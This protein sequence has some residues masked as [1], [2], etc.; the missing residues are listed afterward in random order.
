MS[1]RK[2]AQAAILAA[3]FITGCGQASTGAPSAATS[4]ARQQP[5]RTLVIADRHEPIDLAPKILALGGANRTKRLFNASLALIDSKGQ[6]RP[7]LAEALPELNTESWRVQPDGSMDTTYRLRAG[8]K[9]QDGEPFGADDFVFAWQVYDSKVGP[10]LSTPQDQIDSVDAPD[11]RTIVIHW[12]SPYP[13]AAALTDTLLDPLPSHLLSQPFAAYKQDPAARDTF[14]NLSFWT[15]DYIGAGPYKLTNWDHGIS[16]EGQAFDGHALGRPKIDR[17][18]ERIIDNE[19]TV[20]TNVLADEVGYAAR[21]TLRF[22]H[23]K[24]LQ[25][26]WEPAGKGRVMIDPQAALFVQTQFRPEYQRSPQLLDVRVRRALAY[27][28]DKQGILE[29]LYDGES[30]IADTYIS[31]QIPYY[32][33]IDRALTKSP[34]DPRQLGQQMSAAGYVQDSGGFFGRAAGDRFRPDFDVANSVDYER[35]Q[36]IIADSW[37]RA[38]IDVQTTVTPNEQQ[39]VNEVRH[40]VP[41]MTIPG[42]GVGAE[43]DTMTSFLTVQ[44]GS[45]ANRWSGNNRGGWSNAEYDADFDAFN[46]VLDASARHQSVAHAMAVLST[47]LPGFPLYYNIYVE[48]AVTSLKGPDIGGPGT[49]DYWNV[50]DWTWQ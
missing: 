12:R 9:W 41:G 49:T 2:F 20:L 14:L 43:R 8:L 16:L 39:R 37:R 10:F 17:I 29:A 19:N 15:N 48:A 3:A 27:G 32:A 35:A 13:D 30:T 31:R 46:S 28:I 45:P 25:S 23:A 40:T 33:E 44:I 34:F 42:A 38:G 18:I 1:I 7:Y 22:N 26:D 11:P 47:E 36:Q 4:P 24:T 50:Q 21:T 6:V 5:T